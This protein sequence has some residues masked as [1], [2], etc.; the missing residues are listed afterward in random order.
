[1]DKSEGACWSATAP[2]KIARLKEYEP[3][4]TVLMDHPYL[5]SWVEEAR[6]Y[7]LDVL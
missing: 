2:L 1:M 3:V 7:L 5:S 6:A 4:L